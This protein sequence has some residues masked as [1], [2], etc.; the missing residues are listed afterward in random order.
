MRN[1][2]FKYLYDCCKFIELFFYNIKKNS[3]LYIVK[4]YVIG[5]EDEFSL[6]DII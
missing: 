3:V 6:M 4:F 5:V 1:F 2:V